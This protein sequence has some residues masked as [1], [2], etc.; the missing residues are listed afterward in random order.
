V[1]PAGILGCLYLFT[2]LSLKTITF[3]LAWNAIGV[4]VYLVYG[5]TQSRLAAA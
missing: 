3:F 1:G 4:L 5:R 2:S